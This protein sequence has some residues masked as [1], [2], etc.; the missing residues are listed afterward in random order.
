[1]TQIKPLRCFIVG[2]NNE[3]S[4]RHLLQTSE[5]Q[6]ITFSFESNAPPIYLHVSM[7]ARIIR[8]QASPSEEVSVRFF[9]ESLQ[10]AFPN[11][12][13]ISKFQDE[14]G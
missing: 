11:N 6:R 9:N 3:Y 10:I 13:L 8:D 4:I 1:M 5:T 2:C 7:F 12:V 14:C